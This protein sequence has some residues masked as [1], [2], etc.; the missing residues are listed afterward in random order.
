MLEFHNSNLLVG[1]KTWDIALSKTGYI[2]EAGRCL[3]MEARIAARKVIIV[4][5][6]SWGK[7]T[8]LGDA[9]RIRTWMEETHRTPGTAREPSPRAG[10]VTSQ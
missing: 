9:S 8:R 10:P 2:E 7:Y 6:D 5:L 4:L 1:R 3:V